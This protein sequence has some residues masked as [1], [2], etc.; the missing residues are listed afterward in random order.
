MD[1][2]AKRTLIVAVAIFLFSSAVAIVLA[3]YENTKNPYPYYIN[4]ANL[5][6][7]TAGKPTDRNTLNFIK[8]SLFNTISYNLDY[9]I[10]NG[11]IEDVLVRPNSFSQTYDE[12][13]RTHSVNF[14]VDIES[15]QQSYGVRYQWSNDRSFITAEYGTLVFCLPIEQLIFGDFQCRYM[16]SSE[17]QVSDPIIRHLPHSTLNFEITAGGLNNNKLTLN[18]TITL[19]AYDE[20]TDADAAIESYKVEVVNWIKSIGQ[21]PDNYNLNY[22]IIR[23]SLF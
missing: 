18:I 13:T 4:I 6:D 12:A 2:K 8:Y 7:F 10:T 20:R 17:N 5:D 14:I 16:M 15:L 3:I 19:S 9:P 1:P 22:N 21:T 23:A 11:E